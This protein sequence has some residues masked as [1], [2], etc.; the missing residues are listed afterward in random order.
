MGKEIGRYY[1]YNRLKISTPTLK[2]TVLSYSASHKSS[3]SNL[4]Q[5]SISSQLDNKESTTNKNNNNTSNTDDIHSFIQNI[6]SY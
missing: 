2:K 3:A 5:T 4:T 6:I 1:K